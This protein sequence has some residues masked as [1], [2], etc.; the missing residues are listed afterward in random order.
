MK[1]ILFSLGVTHKARV[2]FISRPPRWRQEPHFK[3]SRRPAACCCCL[4]AV[5]RVRLRRNAKH[6]RG[7]VS[8]M[9]QRLSSAVSSSSKFPQ[10]IFTWFL[11]RDSIFRV[12]PHFIR[13]SSSVGHLHRIETSEAARLS[14]SETATANTT[15]YLF[16]HRLDVLPVKH[17]NERASV[18]WDWLLWT[19]FSSSVMTGYFLCPT[20]IISADTVS[21]T[22]G[23]VCQTEVTQCC[24]T[25]FLLFDEGSPQIWAK[26]C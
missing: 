16:P 12:C 23:T 20:E 7:S 24:C 18:S 6:T 4:C 8:N 11:Y 2:K 19:T 1:E 26:N 13:Q 3:Q 22:H 25:G 15:K 10:Q 14:S 17:R 9:I 5:Q 21:L